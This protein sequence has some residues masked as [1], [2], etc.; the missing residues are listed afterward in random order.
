MG[1]LNFSQFGQQLQNTLNEAEAVFNQV[2]PVF[3]YGSN[4]DREKNATLLTIGILITNSIK[5]LKNT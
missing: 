2:L 4:V 1:D 5:D 3:A